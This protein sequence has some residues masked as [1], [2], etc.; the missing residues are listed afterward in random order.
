MEAT[1]RVAG[2]LA[3]AWGTVLVGRGRDLFE[4]VQGHSPSAGE[5]AAVTALGARHLVQGLTQLVAPH[6]FNRLEAVVDILHA[7]SM[8]LIAVKE[9]SSRRATLTSGA[10]AGVFGVLSLLT[11]RAQEKG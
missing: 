7:A 9:P 6:H 11:A 5:Q 8:V 1:T 3:M 2:A 10:I 4:S